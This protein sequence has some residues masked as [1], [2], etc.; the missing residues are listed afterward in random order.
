MRRKYGIQPCV[1]ENIIIV[2]LYKE[3]GKLIIFVTC[4]QI[5]VLDKTK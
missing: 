2:Y 3:T 4:D 5:I 1:K